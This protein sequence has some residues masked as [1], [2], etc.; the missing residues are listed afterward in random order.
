M[1]A[2]KKIGIALSIAV[3]MGLALGA[4]SRALMR[5]ATIAAGGTP[6]FSWSG[7]FFI[8][9][10]HVVAA[11][12][13]AVLAAFT[14]RWWRWILGAAGAALLAV[15]SSSIASVELG[16][17]STWSATQWAGAMTATVAIFA[18]IVLLPIATVRLIDVALTRTRLRQPPRGI[19]IAS[20]FAE[21]GAA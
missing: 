19:A 4:L 17:T 3:V 16:E 11:V 5:A 20:G 18:T 6:S 8:V 13:V 1:Q 7:T 21:S 15:P 10:I 14:T 9:L 2:L 12:P